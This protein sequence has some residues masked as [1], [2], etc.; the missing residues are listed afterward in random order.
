MF[1][2]LDKCF[3]RFGTA[4]D[5]RQCRDLRFPL[6]LFLNDPGQFRFMDGI[7]R[8]A[9][10]GTGRDFLTVDIMNSLDR[11]PSIFDK[12]GADNAKIF[13]GFIEQRVELRADVAA[14]N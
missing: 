7:H 6:G 14:K 10:E 11:L 3:Q 8:I 2:P 13:A 5:F 1:R 9:A 4:A 12:S